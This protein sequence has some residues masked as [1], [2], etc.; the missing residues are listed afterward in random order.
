MLEDIMDIYVIKPGDTL[1]SIANMFGVS[2]DKL[3]R[4]N[5]LTDPSQLVPGQMLVIVYPTRTHTVLEGESLGSIAALYN[6]TISEILRN[7]QFIADMQY[8]YPGQELNISFNRTARVETFGYTNSFIDRNR[9]AKTLPYLTY[10][11]IFNYIIDENGEVNADGQDTDIIEMAILYGVIPLLHLSTISVQ[12]ELDIATSYKILIDD[13][14][15]DIIIENVLNIIRNKG[16]YGVVIS[17]QTTNEYNQYLFSNYARKFS[18]RLDQEG[19]KTLITIDP[20]IY[21]DEISLLYKVIDYGT[22]SEA[23]DSIM[24]LEFMWGIGGTPPG[25]LISVRDQDL[26][27]NYVLSQTDPENIIVGFP[28]F[29]YSWEIPYISG[30]SSSDFLTRYNVINLARSVGVN[31]QFDETSQNTYF[32]YG[33]LNDDNMYPYLVWSVNAK[34]VDSLVKLVLEKGIDKIG[35]WNIMFFYAQLWLVVT[36]QYEIVKYLPEV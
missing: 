3:I 30:Y 18:D 7:N 13:D 21:S 11:P 33:D 14:F 5:E 20:G 35:I 24:L 28:T 31:I 6:I 2:I 32:Y 29:G 15:Q 22:M 1:V 8:I 9:L 12:G 19:Y 10:L 23:V 26:F 16:Y 17:A 34:T 36:S 4:E 25:P 27:L